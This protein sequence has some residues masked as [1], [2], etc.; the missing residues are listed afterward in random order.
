LRQALSNT[1]AAKVRRI[2]EES[3]ETQSKLQSAIMRRNKILREPFAGQSI[4][5]LTVCSPTINFYE[6]QLA[7]FADLGKLDE[8]EEALSSYQNRID[9]EEYLEHYGV[10][11][12]TYLPTEDIGLG[13]APTEPENET[14]TILSSSMAQTNVS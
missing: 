5:F 3:L 12:R 8:L 1:S 2:L 13:E 10:F 7:Q 6:E 9:R 11:R 14:S 4:G